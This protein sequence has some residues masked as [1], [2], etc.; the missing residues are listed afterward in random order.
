MKMVDIVAQKMPSESDVHMA[1]SFLTKILRSSMRRN[2]PMSR[3][4]SWHAT[5]LNESHS[6]AKPQS[7][8]SPVWQTRYDASPFAAELSSGW[9]QTNLR[10]VS[11][12]FS[13]LGSMDSLEHSSHPYPPG[14]L[15]PSKS[16]NNSI[17]HL[18]GSKRDSAYSSFSTS[19][20]TPDYT[21]SKSNTASTENM[22][23]KINQWDSSGRHSNGRHSQQ[24][25]EGIRQDEKPGFQQHL[26]STGNHEVTKAEEQPGTRHSSSGRFSIGPV[27]HIPELK[28]NIASCTPPPTP[29]TRSDSFAATKIHEKGLTTSTSEGHAVHVQLK[30]QVKSIQKAGEAYESSQ[31]SHQVIETV[32]EGRQEFNQPPKK[33]SSNTRIPSDSLQY[34]HRLPAD[35][36]YSLSTTDIRDVRQPYGHVPHHPKQYSDEGTFHAQTRTVPPLKPPFSGYFSSMQELPTN[37][38]MQ[39]SSQNQ[40][41]RTPASGVTS[42]H[43]S[44]GVMQ[45]SIVRVDE[46][47]TSS[48]S[49]FSHSRRESIGSQGGTKERHSQN[50]DHK[51]NNAAFKQSDAPCN[52]VNVSSSSKHSDLRVCQKQHQ[53]ISGSYPLSKHSEH[54]RSAGH[55][56]LEEHSQQSF[57]STNESKICPQKTPMLY[58][59]AQECNDRSNEINGCNVQQEALDSQNTKQER[60][61]DRFA[62]SL[63]NEIQ[64]RR[65]QLQKSCSA[66]TLE[67]PVESAEEGAVWNMN[68]TGSPSSDGCFTVSYKDH[69]KEAQARVLQATSFR[70]KDL[71]PVLFDHPVTEGPSLS[72]SEIP[73]SKSTSGSN[74]VLR[75]GSRKR[76]SLEKKVQSFSEP[77]KIHEVGA[78]ESSLVPDNVAHL[79][80]QQRFFESTGKPAF[81]K[82][83]PK[84]TLQIYEG[85]RLPNLGGMHYSGKSDCSR[86][87]NSE[88]STPIEQ[89]LNVGQEGYLSVNRQVMLEQRRLGTFAEYE[90]KWNTQRKTSEPRVSGRY[91]SADNILETGKEKRS[92][93]TCVHE[94]SRSSP[95]ADFYGQ[96][97]LVQEKESAVFSKPERTLS[98]QE[99][100]DERLNEKAYSELGCKEKAAPPLTE[101]LEKKNADPPTNHHK[102]TLNLLDHTTR[103]APSALSKNKSSV[104]LTHLEKYKCLE[105]TPP[106]PPSGKFQEV[107][108]GT[109]GGVQNSVSAVDNQTSSLSFA[110][111]PW[112]ASEYNKELVREEEL[113]HEL[114]APPFPP[115]PPPVV[116]PTQQ[117]TGGIQP[118][119][120]GQRSPS[121]QFAPQRLTDKPPV[122]LSKQDE[123]PGRM[124]KVTDENTAVKKVPIKIVHSESDAEK[125]SRQY[126]NLPSETPASSQGIGATHLQSLGQSYS[127]FCTYTRQKDQDPE[128][129]EPEMGPLKDQGLQTNLN[130]GAYILHSSQMG[131]SLDQS[132]NGV[133]SLPSH[134]EDDEKRKELARDIMDKDKSLVDILDQSKMKTTMDLM[135]GIFPQGE[136]L[137]EEAQHRRKVQPK[138]LSPR[139]SVEKKE[140]DSLVVATALVTNSTY[141]STSAPKAELLI[142]MKDMQEQSV[143]H[144][145]EDELEEDNESDLA[146]KKHELI[147]SLSKKLQVLREAQESLQEDVQD[148]NALGEEV[149]AI[150]QGVCKPNELD[151]FRM[152]VGDLDKVVNLLLSLS[153]RLARVENALNS[154][155]EDASL[156]ERRT[157]TDKRKLLIR[158]HEDAKELKENLDRRERAV[159][160]ILASYLPDE[161]MAD[162]EHFVKMKSALII[163]QRKLEDKIK[164]GEEQLKCLTDSL[165]MDQ[166]TTN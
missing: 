39:P 84:Q 54:K 129:L 136:Q 70:R 122:S 92:N 49:E 143:E 96:K 154:L 22:L 148:N 64:V 7:T 99:K 4:H 156:E 72:P 65:A 73:P 47:K 127:L 21:L 32:L 66:A 90:A 14:R 131:S 78:D 9:E 16:N 109:Q 151:K 140:E 42:Q 158:Q 123:A 100:A 52:F 26:L 157:L 93:S 35:K 1:R 152:F 23:Y 149:E 118:S 77:D 68:S 11:D 24:I 38:Q 15:S 137:L 107:Q 69:L 101:D 44:Q 48:V 138:S 125:E 159:Y 111:I 113:L 133:S 29:P 153:G 98:E 87:S 117:I 108:S 150:V 41:S 112:K 19:S 61:S 94:R 146:C 50:H 5:K 164:L 33:H 12:Q 142:K 91:H 166:R 62:T 71:E 135:E 161:N 20:G 40:I 25:S 82:P 28:K 60:R 132:S 120:D 145:S 56:H 83:M 95:S 104:L 124:D 85:T 128:P 160:E 6:E 18:G 67:S 76:F 144:I 10:R 88:S 13:S 86:R 89:H 141:Y 115:P 106:P 74:Q 121:P 27:W 81:L 45:A 163:E 63:R 126:L 46:D 57:Q 79:E 34:L 147:E 102:P 114:V 3:P 58:S 51:G 53:E 110:P 31:R 165:P 37:N 155:E 55:R 134:S 105:D 80:S 36:P 59:L 8:P 162:Y 2:E 103:S 75:I 116:L 30:S 139:N 43:I 119:M 17:E 97:H 130:P